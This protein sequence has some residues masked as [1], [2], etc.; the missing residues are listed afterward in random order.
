M[1]YE[2]YQNK[3]Q[4]IAA[5][6]AKVLKHIVLICATLAT[7]AVITAALLA[8]KG[9]TG[10]VRCES[11]VVYGESYRCTATS[12]LSSV[13][14]EYRNLNS[15]RWTDVQPTMPGEYEVRA[16]GK[17]SSGKDR[18]GKASSFIIE[19]CRVDVSVAEE[20]VTFG[21]L[22][23]VTHTALAYKDSL[24]CTGFAYGDITLEKTTV[25]PVKDAIK[26]ID[27]KGKDVTFAY[28]I[29]V[30]TKDI[31]FTKRPLTVIT[32]SSS[33]VY[34]ANPFTF[35][36]YEVSRDT[37]LGI[38][39]TVSAKFN[40]LTNVGTINN[41]AK[42][43][44]YHNDKGRV[45]DVT[46]QYNLS[47]VEGQLSVTQRPITITTGSKSVKYNGIEASYNKFKIESDGYGLAAGHRVNVLSSSAP[48]NVG[49]WENNMT[50]QI[51]DRE[52]NDV[53]SNYSILLNV[54]TIEIARAPIKAVSQSTS[55]VY[56]GEEHGYGVATVKGIEN[57]NHD[58]MVVSASR[59]KDVGKIDNEIEIKIFDMSSYYDPV[60]VTSNYDIEYGFGTIEVTPRPL[61]IVTHGGNYIYGE[62]TSLPVFDFDV[63]GELP[64]FHELMV[65]VEMGGTETPDLDYWE[66]PMPYE[67]LYLDVGSYKNEISLFVEDTWYGGDVTSNY[68]ITY[69]YG[70]ITVEPRDVIVQ[71]G[72]L[73]VVYDGEEHGTDEYTFKPG[74]EL[75]SGHVFVVESFPKATDAG[76]YENSFI[77]YNIESIRGD[78]V[79]D[80]YNIAWEY[81]TIE[82]EKRPIFVE[83]EYVELMY[84]GRVHKSSNI[85]I[86]F[87]SPYQLVDGDTIEAN[88]V[89]ER[90]IVGE[91]ESR[92]TGVKVIHSSGREITGN[93]DIT[94]R[95]GQIIIYPRPILIRT[96]S[97]EKLYD[98]TPLT[99]T[100]YMLYI[101]WY[102]NALVDGHYIEATV[103]GSQT[104]VGES[105]NHLDTEA[106]YIMSDNADEPGGQDVT[107]NYVIS[108]EYG[109]LIVTERAH[110]IVTSYS[111]SK[112]Y[113]GEPLVNPNYSVEIKLGELIDGHEIIVDVYGTITEIGYADNALSVEIVD[114]Y[115]NDVSF[116]YRVDVLPGR[117]T[118]NPEAEDPISFGQIKNDRDG[119]IYLKMRSYGSFN[120]R[121][122]NTAL[123][124]GK[125]LPG[126][127][128]YDYLTSYAL[129][130][131]GGN[132]NT[133][134]FKDLV[135][136][137]LPYYMGFD[138]DYLRPSSD[139]EY[140]YG[141]S[142]FAM[143]YY[144]IPDNRNGYDY[145][146]G[147]LGSYAE[148]EAEY[149]EFVYSQ[150]L[151]IDAET[152]DYMS[153][154][155]AEQGFD[156]NDPN[157]ISKIARYIQAAASYNLDYDPMLDYESNVAI[158][159]LDKY[160]EGKCTHYATA[161]TLLYRA[162][163]IPARYVEGF[164]VE[165]KK[166][167]FVDI[168]SPGHAWVEV[169]IDGVGWIQVEVTGSG[170]VN[171][172]LDKKETITVTPAYTHKVYDGSYLYPD[173]RVDADAALSKLL[174]NGYTYDVVVSGRQREVGT[175]ASTI[176]A[177][178]LYDS[179]GNDV[180]EN[181]NIVCRNGVLQ[182]FSDEDRTIKI[183][184][185]QLQKYYDGTPLSYTEDDYEIIHMPD[186][187]ELVLTLNISLTDV[188]Y[189][190][191]TDINEN[192]SMYATYKVYRNGRNVTS[193]YT[194]VFDIFEGT[195]PSYVPI[196]VSRRPIEL[197]SA[198]Q[199]KEEDGEPLTNP[200]VFVSY[201]SL[202]DGHTLSAVAT[203]YIDS[204]GVVENIVDINSINIFDENGNSVLSNYD[205]LWINN[206]TLTIVQPLN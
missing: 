10:R 92:L 98:G 104:E 65:S 5:F 26:I 58:Y 40:S 196:T 175:S 173:Q 138:G 54:G 168:M 61:T 124:Y 141:W 204:V 167:T 171:D 146:K 70:T 79:T 90:A 97:D 9:I 192:I 31:T 81:G 118:I 201:G 197:T 12:F 6:L 129:L 174:A 34:D 46:H 84:D 45:L 20:S 180:T 37:S 43:V 22:P 24:E 35:D 119:Y 110:I 86:S 25:S 38:G 164:M 205:I 123:A 161:A 63:I 29:N 17:S 78:D 83:P 184:L 163:G 142:D 148:Y 71:T 3:I 188:G 189:L 82:I 64:Y 170:S 39:D 183:Y 122:W 158:A 127:L 202:A 41:E 56:D 89:G 113:D 33:N 103:L 155:I 57:A 181:Y 153:G 117:L 156:I 66:E 76:R 85:L 120:G 109:T 114:S 169:Y 102:Y 125:M 198:T 136:Y 203:G 137:M 182:V 130:N 172:D 108:Y 68:D 195:D 121:Y 36:Q 48:V 16:V 154:I 100:D 143:T 15:K 8:T 162:L 193:D 126:G 52:G 1:L 51:V 13:R 150:Y 11:N 69:E 140:L 186:G 96:A 112:I 176:E 157:V 18:Y 72:S 47:V 67:D 187:I 190:T 166:D 128:S 101:D 44:I 111:D 60:D 159:F 145:L 73:S 200:S 106:I 178:I 14:Y 7:V 179:D 116:L 53:T 94:T 151:A 93:Y 62:L 95:T 19:P 139:V 199:S 149:R 131:S 59:I 49:T 144:S 160:Q 107:S 2:N 4:R 80:N 27:S 194:L 165:T 77:R 30:V 177:F 74:Y 42:I 50:F 115:G 132:I 206:G 152:L 147:N 75:L 88:F 191:L 135:M 23:G 28:Q 32:S 91:S 55:I 134:E 21:D 133:V 105:L 99:N 87:D 185:Y